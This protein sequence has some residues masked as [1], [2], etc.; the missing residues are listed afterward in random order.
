[1]QVVE[2]MFSDI[3]IKR[4]HTLYLKLCRPTNVI[5]S[6]IQS[7]VDYNDYKKKLIGN[8]LNNLKSFD[9]QFC[10]H[11]KLELINCIQ[12]IV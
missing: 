6:S 12:L 8:Y 3:G 9:I 11:Q 4:S 10:L 1:M 2:N 5:E 7:I